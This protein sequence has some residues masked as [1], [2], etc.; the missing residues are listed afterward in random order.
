MGIAR[1]IKSTEGAKEVG[2]LIRNYYARAREVQ[3][4]GWKTAWCMHGVPDELL[5]A[6]G[7]FPSYPENYATVCASKQVATNLIE[8]AEGDGFSRDLC[9]YIRICFG[10]AKEMQKAGGIPP[11]SPFGGMPLPDMLISIS[12]VCDPRVKIFEAMRRY[13]PVPT[14]IYDAIRP[15]IDDPKCIDPDLARPY[16]DY[17]VEQLK[18]LVAFLEEQTGNRLDED[19]LRELVSNALETHRLF[20][21]VLQTRKSVPCP[22]ASTDYFAIIFPFMWM[23]G[24]REAVDFYRNLLEEVRGRAKS[25]VGVIPEEKYRLL[26]VGLPP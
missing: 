4:K 10:Y 17:N 26:W 3:Q 18:G 25:K 7:V 16:L 14:Y 12:R 8:L 6:M 24:E 15:P 19:R 2:K 21:E 22:M 1:P 9:A 13:L 23:A 5:L 20:Y 11:D